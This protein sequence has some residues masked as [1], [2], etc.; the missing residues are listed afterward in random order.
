MN[1]NQFTWRSSQNY[2][3]SYYHLTFSESIRLIVSVICTWLLTTTT[4]FIENWKITNYITFPPANS[5]WTNRG[6]GSWRHITKTNFNN[7]KI[8]KNTSSMIQNN[9]TT[10]CTEAESAWETLIWLESVT[11]KETGNAQPGACV[12]V[13]PRCW[14]CKEWWYYADRG[15]SYLLRSV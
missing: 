2:T 5:L 13:L 7:Y 11:E 3:L 1:E 15:G 12:N 4:N 6:G 9:W 8:V 10:S 14:P